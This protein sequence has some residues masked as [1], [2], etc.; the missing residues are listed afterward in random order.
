[1]KTQ[2]LRICVNC[3][4]EKLFAFTTSPQN[5]PLWIDSILEEWIEGGALEKGAIFR[6]RK[7]LQGEAGPSFVVT[8]I[9]ENRLFALRSLESTYECRYD[10]SV[11]EGGAE[12]CYSELNHDG[13][14]LDDP[15]DQATLDR[16]RSVL[17]GLPC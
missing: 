14:D 13:S 10:Y 9:E 5:T 15:M 12:L 17:E 4:V 6:Q 3:S 8:A 11:S 16:L 1:M 2:V 7:R